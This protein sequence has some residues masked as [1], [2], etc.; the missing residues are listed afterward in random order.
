MKLRFSR[1]SLNLIIFT[2]IV[3]IGWA[4]IDKN[5]KEDDLNS[6][7][8]DVISPL[9]LMNLE[10]LNQ[11]SWTSQ[12]GIQVIWQS[13]LDTDF[14]IRVRGAR[15][16][17]T[18][19]IDSNSISWQPAYWQWDINL[20]A[21]FEI[22]LD[23]FS[24]KLKKFPAALKGKNGSIILQGPW[25]PE[26][27]RL[28]SARII[29]DLD[30]KPMNELSITAN[31]NIHHCPWQPVSAQFWLQDQLMQTGLSQPSMI[32]KT[33]RIEQLPEFSAIT[34]RSLHSWKQVFSQQW[35]ASWVKP[36]KQFDMLSDLA[37][38]RLPANYLLQGYWQINELTPAVLEDYLA[39]CR[40]DV[41]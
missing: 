41:R 15:T 30:F 28:I 10:P 12:E 27:A 36:Q 21:D 9:E 3:L 2:C 26:I 6:E 19:S 7:T 18:P 4:S 29:K 40:R 24:Q 32:S 39:Q 5:S 20:G 16:D 17:K 31:S 11:Q 34:A 38:Y 1:T 35:Q 25:S 33:W 23:V 22:G 13:R 37:Y 8:M 14:L